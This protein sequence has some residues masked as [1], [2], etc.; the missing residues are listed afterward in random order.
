M[1]HLLITTLLIF[2][3]GFG[4]KAQY[5]FSTSVTTN[6]GITMVVELTTT[7]ISINGQTNPP[8]T[9]ESGYNFNVLFDYSVRFYKNGSERNFKD[10][11]IYTLQGNFVCDGKTSFFDIPNT[12]GEGSGETVGNIWVGESTCATA[13]VEDLICNKI[14][15]EI[16]LKGY[17][18]N[19][20]SSIG[21]STLP[22]ELITFD[23]I[24]ND[25]QVE[26]SWK[27]ATETNNDFFSIERSADGV[28]WETVHTLSGAGNSSQVSAYSWID[29][30][31]YNGVSYYRL[32]QTDY[33]G[34]TK[35][36]HIVSVEQEDVKE[37]QAY[38]NPVSQTSSL[39]GVD[40]NKPVRI[41]N[42]LGVEVTGNVKISLSPSKKTLLDMSQLPK[43][44][45]Y[46]VNGDKSIRLLKD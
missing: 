20:I 6:N 45:Y 19:T 33:D 27:T 9:C 17:G 41:F 1:K 2:T 39:L 36:F 46:V 4:A 29:Y 5:Q 26:L 8:Y 40:S 15:F 18:W 11:D 7:G 24:K 25:R 28:A 10:S 22:I 30:S 13:T 32:R 31:P 14:V 34:T 42:A 12:T 43:G 37:L 44:M 3:V 21:T 38:P 35:S 23:A 16:Q